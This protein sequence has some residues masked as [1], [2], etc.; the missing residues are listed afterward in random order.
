[1]LAASARV[2]WRWRWSG[3]WPSGVPPPLRGASGL[4]LCD[5]GSSASPIVAFTVPAERAKPL[6]R[7]VR[8]AR[9]HYSLRDGRFRFAP[10]SYNDEAD[11]DRT[12]DV[13][14]TSLQT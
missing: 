12:V 1:M 13:I 4:E 2:W 9:I 11:S 8:D 5:V 6:H 14:T 7:A 3:D 10:H